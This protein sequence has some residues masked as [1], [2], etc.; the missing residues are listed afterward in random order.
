MRRYYD[1]MERAAA[2]IAAAFRRRARATY[3]AV[4]QAQ[5]YDGQRRAEIITIRAWAQLT[6]A[7]AARWEALVDQEASMEDQ[8]TMARIFGFQTWLEHLLSAGVEVR[9]VDLSRAQAPRA[10][11]GAYDM[12]GAKLTRDGRMQR[13]IGRDIGKLVEQG[14]PIARPE[15]Y[16]EASCMLSLFLETWFDR[17]EV[18]R[19][20]LTLAGLYK[21]ATGLELPPDGEPAGVTL[22]EC[23]AWL[24]YWRLNG[25]AINV[26]GELIWRFDSDSPNHH[27]AGGYTWSLLVHDQHVWSIAR[28]TP[29]KAFARAFVTKGLQ[30]IPF[31]KEL[32][33]SDRWRWPPAVESGSAPTVVSSLEDIVAAEGAQCITNEDPEKLAIAAWEAGYE[34]GNIRLKHGTVDR[35]ALRVNGRAVSIGR[36]IDGDVRDDQMVSSALTARSHMAFAAALDKL[37]AAYQPRDGLSTYS[38]SLSAAFRNYPRGP[39]CGRL[40]TIDDAAAFAEIDVC[41]AYTSILAQCRKIPVFSSFD[42]LRPYC[43]GPIDELAFYSI[44][45]ETLDPILFPQRHDLVPG[46]TV[47]YAR[48]C[49]VDITVLAEAV[50]CRAIATG[51]PALLRA[52]YDNEDISDQS[53]KEIAN[54][55]YGL[56]NKGTAR[57]QCAECYLDHD[58]ALASG[59]YMLALGPGWLSVKQAA[60]DLR[61]GYLPVG[62]IILD[63]MR[64]L[65]HRLVSALAAAGTPALAVR[66]DAAY[67]AG[68]DADA[69]RTALTRAG[70]RFGGVDWLRVGA[71]RVSPRELA[72]LPTNMLAD[73]DAGRLGMVPAV[74]VPVP[75]CERI[76]LPTAV[77]DATV[78]GAW[79]AIDE[80]MP[81]HEV[82]ASD[83]DSIDALL[84][85][86]LGETAMRGP[87]AIEAVVPGAGKT[88]LVK[89][90]IDR[91]NQRDTALIV[92]PWNALV[93]ACR[94]EGY[95]AL[96]LHELCGKIIAETEGEHEVKRAYDVTGVTH[97][98]FEEAYLYTVREV[99][100]LATFMRK[101]PTI[102]YTLAG[103]PGQLAPVHQE[104][105]VDSD[106]WYEAAFASLF[107][108]RL[109]LQISKRVEDPADRVRMRRLCDELA[110]G[111]LPV[112]TILDN[113]GLERRA[114]HD[115]TDADAGFPH[116]AAT[117]STMARV[118]FWVHGAIGMALAG[119]YLVGEELLGVDGTRCRGGRIASNETYTV[120]SVD[121]VD[122]KL[123]AP[124][125][126]SRTVKLEQAAR[127][128]KRPYCRTGHSTQGLSLGDRI[129]IHD[130]DCHMATHRW[131]RTVV[132]RCRTLDIII[133]TNS[134][135]V[136]M[137]NVDVKSRIA[138]H[139]ASDTAAG[140]VWDPAD[141]V[142]AEDVMAKL[143]RQRYGCHACAEPLDQDWSIDR[144]VNELPHLR[145]NVAISC[146]RCQ[147]ASAHRA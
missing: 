7:A 89:S 34:P 61:E 17:I 92:C 136:R 31:S 36:A 74:G 64:C 38:A 2:A 22:R 82:A 39:R 75:A 56:C 123:A 120:V 63:G 122:L 69:A 53:R 51:G 112:T 71:L 98:H 109:C 128:L 127:Y 116:I 50:P 110:E 147:H 44:R 47:T 133:V 119:E 139:T 85:E 144:L 11:L 43:G 141:Y 81:R 96:T 84:A 111:I 105:R 137:R 65:L 73:M 24:R 14:A 37:R 42:E 83:L 48:A 93:S 70:F 9:L 4:F 15:F 28:G 142:T 140:F 121:T 46:S 94:S 26:R 33:V 68:T 97:V 1:T 80:L 90:W 132:S 126:S 59:G 57:R 25:R 62:R 79:G 45:A 108:R 60:R 55:V 32:A 88:F 40:T 134:S 124:D 16:R 20:S 30:E 145:D 143:R 27:L 12:A 87:L 23:E 86:L 125:G 77:E 35:F 67:I 104:L 115:M 52:L 13:T 102:T 114:F 49:G 100:W 91:T 113:A 106:G 76:I 131:M 3:A 103:D 54:I 29:E 101:H 146:R 8:L 78:D 72:T 130:V 99:E 41:R 18:K 21:M 135:G 10:G 118:D 138:G 5:L 129:F 117:R 58:E 66:T 19:A 6:G 107:P 95:R